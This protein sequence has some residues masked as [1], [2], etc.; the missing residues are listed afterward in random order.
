MLPISLQ[1]PTDFLHEEVR[2]GYTISVDIKKVWAVELDLLNEFIRVCKKYNIQFFAAGGTI[3]GAIR[4]KGFIPWDDDIDI[5]MFR[6]EYERLCSIAPMEFS[7]PYFFQT[8]ETDPGSYRGHAQLRN[9]M[10]T[11]ILKIELEQKK[12]INQ[13][14]FIDI[15]PLDAVPDDVSERKVFYK[16]MVKK[17]KRYWEYVNYLYPYRFQFRKNLFILFENLFKSLLLPKRTV[18]KKANEYYQ[19]FIKSIVG[20]SQNSNTVQMS[21]FCMERYTYN[22]AD[23]QDFVEKPF[24]MLMIPVPVNY[25]SVLDKTY[26]EWSKFVVGG[27]LHGGMIFDTEESYKEYIK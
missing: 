3:L 5:M 11:S 6:S 19:D 2:N 25:K 10:T 9:S 27:S 23:I 4:H 1:L 12:T 18:L 16:L 17:Q 24:E 8:E 26:G 15:F 21:P 22:K 14:I 20:G 7:H 13:G